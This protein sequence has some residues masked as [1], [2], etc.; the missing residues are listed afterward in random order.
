MNMAAGQGAAPAISTSKSFDVFLSFSGKDVR[1]NLLS[2]LYSALHERKKI[3]TFKDDVDIVRGD[4]IKESLDKA[5]QESKFFVVIFSENYASSS[6][7]LNELVHMIQSCA[8]DDIERRILPVFHGVSVT[9]VR[10]QEGI[11][12]TKFSELEK[13]FKEK[14]KDEI[15][16]GKLEEA[17]M[18]QQKNWKEALTSVADIAGY[19][20]NTIRVES[21]LVDRIVKD[22][23]KKMNVKLLSDELKGLIGIDSRIKAIQGLLSKCYSDV[24]IIGV[25]GASGMGKT[26]LANV[27]FHQLFPQFKNRYFLQNVREELRN[28]TCSTLRR[29][30]FARLFEED[31]RSI[32]LWTETLKQRALKTNVLIVLDDLSSST[33]FDDI[34]LRN[35]IQFGKESIIL[36]TTTDLQVLKSIK[37]CEK[38][39][40]KGLNKDES[41]ELFCSYAFPN[42]ICPPGWK[43]LS[44]KAVKLAGG[45]GNPFALKVLGS[46][47]RFKSKGELKRD[48]PNLKMTSFQEVKDILKKGYD[49]LDDVGKEIFL[50]IACFFKGEER[51][52]VESLLDGCHTF[53]SHGGI[54]DLIN[55]SRIQIKQH[56]RLWMD[57]LTQE[58]GQEIVR[59]K[60]R[61]DL[62]RRCRLWDAE[63]ICEVLENNRGTE[64]IG[65]IFLNVTEI[66]DS[67]R[68]RSDVFSKMTGL[69]LLKIY[70]P[71]S[72]RD[73]KVIVSQ[74]G[75]ES[76]PESL[77]YFHWHGCPL[78]CLPSN[79]TA[80]NLVELSIPYSQVEDLWNE[81]QNLGKLKRIDLRYS[82][83]LIRA[84]DFSSASNLESIN[85]ECCKSLL[86]L[87]L[88]EKLVKL[89]SLNLNGCSSLQNLSV[90]PWNITCLHIKNCT[91]LQSIPTSIFDLKSLT[92]LDLFGC[93]NLKNFPEI[94]T[95]MPCLIDL[96]LD[97]TA[98][99][100]LPPSIRKLIALE[101]LSLNF[102][103]NLEFLPESI[104]CIYSLQNL[105]LRCCPNIKYL[106]SLPPSLASV[107]ARGCTALQRV[108]SSK[109][110]TKGWDYKPQNI[111]TFIF[112]NCLNLHRDAQKNIMADA[113]LR[114][115]HIA[116][117]TSEY[118]GDPDM[119]EICWPGNEIPKWLNHQ[120][121]ESSVNVTL[122]SNHLE[123]TFLGFIFCIVVE[124]ERCNLDEDF[125]IRCEAP[126]VSPNG[127]A[128]TWSHTWTWH[129]NDRN[130]RARGCVD[131]PH[132]F[133]FYDNGRQIRSNLGAGNDASSSSSASNAE[134]VPV[135]FEFQLRDCKGLDP[136]NCHVKRCGIRLLY[137]GEPMQ[138]IEN[139]EE[140]NERKSNFGC[141]H[142]CSPIL[143]FCESF[144]LAK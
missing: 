62:G 42:G 70:N 92:K 24:R 107:D 43:N 41:R 16:E 39:R 144:W 117:V 100:F 55:K 28:Q 31:D 48:L 127:F 124:F 38:Y 2:H 27:L 105:S 125:K 13:R 85:L 10:N 111:G 30:L 87:P 139:S 99:N 106:P 54:D 128:A 97:R 29:M 93:S 64:A 57:G 58:M 104:S 68:L 7:C 60:S 72:I 101:T 113:L 77:V 69:R 22:V 79:F 75:L 83:H 49:Y 90:L 61:E 91:K 141:L 33:Q 1:D 112:Y 137:A 8:S 103:E 5:I 94:L 11:Y 80:K 136:S 132:V 73:C 23:E 81:N 35:C 46:H 40:L 95:P 9:T 109:V 123:D 32:E 135:K 12:K 15:Q 66:K 102:C 17:W 37:G 19:S 133:L 140:N 82:E 56:N 14:M 120:S 114:I 96:I 51:D 131:S 89:T 18:R 84:P 44:E 6:W 65:G 47:L 20:T 129:W 108:S 88:D 121:E 142:L 26:A 126:C 143:E 122:A 52:Y 74:E 86:E 98:I 78:K 115:K 36:V 67:L 53:S 110:N 119:T 138:M 3:E 25:W 50:D 59:D 71:H 63:E 21:Q 4:K 130:E 134:N 76:L 118:E 116:N 34:L 45:R